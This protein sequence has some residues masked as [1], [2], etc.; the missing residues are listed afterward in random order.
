VGSKSL[1]T[2]RVI[3]EFEG[4]PSELYCGKGAH[5]QFEGEPFVILH[6]AKTHSIF[7]ELKITPTLGSLSK[8]SVSLYEEC[9]EEC[10]DCNPSS[11]P[12]PI[13]EVGE[14]GSGMQVREVLEGWFMDFGKCEPWKVC[15]CCNGKGYLV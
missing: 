1:S 10:E 12:K 14:K 5:T 2:L 4:G 13:E 11:C 15:E 9:E 8:K 7:R 6:Y 3:N